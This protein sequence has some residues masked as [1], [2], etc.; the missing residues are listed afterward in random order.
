M[1]RIGIAGIGF[2]GMIHFLAAQRVHGARVTALAS[3]DPRKRAGDWTSIRGNFGP[4]GTQM[5][6][7]GVTCFDSFDQL[8]ADPN[9]DLIDICS[10]TIQHPSMAIAALRAGKHVLV[11]KPIALS[12][13]DA[14]AMV[15]E[16]RNTKGR[17]LVGHVLPFFPEFAWLADAVRSK[18]YGRLLAGHFQRIIARPDWSAT[19][20]DIEQ[21]GGPAIDLHIHDTHFVRMICGMPRAV[22][23][24]GRVEDNAIV[25][26]QAQYLFG[27]DGPS[28]ACSS[29]ALCQ[30]G[31]PFMHGYEVYFEGGTL[32]YQSGV[33]PPTLLTSD[34]KTETPSLPCSGDPVDCFAA[35]LQ[36]AVS[37]IFGN[38]LCPELDG[39]LAR[40]ALALCHCECQSVSSGQ[41][42]AVPPS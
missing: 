6:L 26:V 42:V 27:D 22:F 23:A 31:R 5:D 24:T 1:L 14:D 39:Q 37:S 3:R 40:D 41:L 32:M 10:P 13:A 38:K 29:G 36:A 33:T 15:G 34:G 19:I 35:E 18:R 17:L 2:M 4:P 9:I 30:P 16:A 25:H 8:C 20:G 11:E 28:I 12:L 7:T 21:T